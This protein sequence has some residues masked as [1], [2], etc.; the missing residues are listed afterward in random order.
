MGSGPA[1]APSPSPRQDAQ[2]EEDDVVRA[3][4][5]VVFNKKP[6]VL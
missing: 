1:G 2:K 6:P 5:D 4:R 3:S